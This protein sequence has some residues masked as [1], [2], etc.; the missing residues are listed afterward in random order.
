MNKFKQ[1]KKAI[2]NPPAER[3]M[4]IEY[5]SHFLQILGVLFVCSILVYKGFWYIIFA[6]IFSLGISYSQ[7]ITAYRKYNMIVNMNNSSYD[8]KKD[9]SPTRK[10]DYII[11]SVSG[12]FVK[13]GVI[14]VSLIVTWDWFGV[15]TWYHKL[16]FPFITIFIFLIIYFFPVYWIAKIFWRKEKK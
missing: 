12:K 9:K 8:Y 13:Y 15:E 1:L 14:L 7:G 3:L 11:E 6:F 16:A 5:Q 10:R 4:K 2:K